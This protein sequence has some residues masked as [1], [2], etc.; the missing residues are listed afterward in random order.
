MGG[1]YSRTEADEIY[2]WVEAQPHKRRLRWT[3][4]LG[5]TDLYFMLTRV[6][7]RHDARFLESTWVFDRCLE[8][9]ADPDNRLDLWFRGGY[10][11]S[12]IT[13]TLTLQDIA[14]DREI[15]VGIFSHT[16][17]NAMTFLEQIMREM[18]DNPILHEVWPDVFW[19]NPKRQAKQW[20]RSSGLIV[21]RS[22][23]PKE[24]TLE[25]WGVV[26]GQPTG[27]H[28][29]L[30][31]YDDLVSREQVGS[32]LMIQKTTGAMELSLNL[33]SKHVRRRFIG[34]R[35]HFADTY[36]DMIKRGMITER[37]YAARDAEGNPRYYDE[38]ELKQKQ[39]EQG[40]ATFSAQMMQNP[41]MDSI[42]GFQEDWL[43]YYEENEVSFHGMNVYIV[44][45]P[46]HSKKKTSD[47][48]SIFVIG[49]S[50][51]KK[52]YVL[53]MIRDRL[54]PTEI[55]KT[56]IRL[57]RYYN[58]GGAAR[59]VKKVAVER[60]GAMAH[61][62]LIYSEQKSQQYRFDVMELGGKMAKA[63][64]IARLQM[65]FQEGLIV[66]PR[67]LF[68][69]DYEGKIKDIIHDFIHLE[70]LPFPAVSHDDQLDC[71]SRIMDD[72]LQLVWP[73]AYVPSQ[74]ELPASRGSQWS[75]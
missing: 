15:T 53:N 27:R 67:N 29:D 24:A 16:R 22:G 8:V 46:A 12:I 32:E 74:D 7:R 61:R 31:I 47:Y 60:Y 25:A 36:H 35:Y 49:L 2:D 6:C 70:Y 21:Q 5:E 1:G 14:K 9:E 57:H 4:A 58:Q 26:E 45:D 73:M 65:P 59:R 75:A 43:R 39:R 11:S 48:T 56:I 42:M 13:Q 72:E 62:D 10:K 23:N 63:D 3:K 17:P 19:S 66:L 28:F 52:Y 69:T 50:P 40:L 68:R 71:L 55:A 18:E 37:V 33:G 38:E 44:C 54:T 41:T 34:T 20:S 51:D 64:R 30:M